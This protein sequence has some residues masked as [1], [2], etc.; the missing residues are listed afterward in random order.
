MPSHEGGSSSFIPSS[1]EQFALEVKFSRLLGL[2]RELG[3]T[4]LAKLLKKSWF[5]DR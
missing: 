4:R 5:R 2:R 3:E 1:E